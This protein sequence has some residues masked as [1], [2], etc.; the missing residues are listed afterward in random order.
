MDNSTVLRNA[1]FASAD[2]VATV[3]KAYV[4]WLFLAYFMKI[5]HPLANYNLLAPL[6]ILSWQDVE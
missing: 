3:G 4:I 5:N 6:V 2:P 1:T